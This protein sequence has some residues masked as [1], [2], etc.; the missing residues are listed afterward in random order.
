MPSTHKESKQKPT[1]GLF[2]RRVFEWKRELTV[3]EKTRDACTT[4]ASFVFQM[5]VCVWLLI[6]DRI[7]MNT[8]L[9]MLDS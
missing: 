8:S 9:V 3:A 4:S 5:S 7:G 6:I 1:D 2:K